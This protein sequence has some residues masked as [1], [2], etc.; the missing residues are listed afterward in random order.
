VHV[1]KGGRYQLTLRG[2]V[3]EAN[4]EKLIEID[5]TPLDGEYRVFLFPNT[6]GFGATPGEWAN[7]VVCSE[8]GDP[9][10]IALTSG[11]HG[12]KLTSVQR[13]GSDQSECRVKEEHDRGENASC[14]RRVIHARGVPRTRKRPFGAGKSLAFSLG[15]HV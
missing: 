7:M 9:L 6:G 13:K 12:I 15:I 3:F 2:A 14:G 11:E 4:A 8:G 5:G 10:A 1:P